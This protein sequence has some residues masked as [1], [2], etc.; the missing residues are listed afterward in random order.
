MIANVSDL[1]PFLQYRRFLCSV[2]DCRF[3]KCIVLDNISPPFFIYHRDL[4]DQWSV[5]I[6]PFF[7]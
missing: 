5:R 4:N 3:S 6:S 2:K 1:L 7:Q